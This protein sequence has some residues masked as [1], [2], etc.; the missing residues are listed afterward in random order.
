[1]AADQARNDDAPA[2]STQQIA[3]EGQTLDANC[4][5][6]SYLDFKPKLWSNGCTG[7][8]ANV[9]RVRWVAW[10][11]RSARG[12]GVAAL[13]GPCVTSAKPGPDCKGEAA[14][15]RARAQVRLD[16]PKTCTDHGRSRRYF[17]RARFAVYMRRGNP[18][19]ESVGWQ[20]QKYGT[21][22]GACRL[23]GEPF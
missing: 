5:N 3:R 17:S 23:K 9:R 14:L 6:T 22:D 16:R 13:R 7:G 20:R 11:R 8:S 1:M 21:F 4:A 18:F 2:S 19:G 15:Y 12:K 10:T